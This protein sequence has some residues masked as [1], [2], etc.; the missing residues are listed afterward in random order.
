ME[1]YRDH[2]DRPGREG[3]ALNRKRIVE[4]T[5]YTVT[6]PCLFFPMRILRSMVS[7][8]SNSLNGHVLYY[9]RGSNRLISIVSKPIKIVVV[10]IVVVVFVQK[11]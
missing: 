11:H 1:G 4:T 8:L 9:V 10:V 2:K 3:V 5:I 6:L 7:S